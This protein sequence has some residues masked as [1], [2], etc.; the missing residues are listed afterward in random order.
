MYLLADSCLIPAGKLGYGVDLG[1]TPALSLQL[2]CSMWIMRTQKILLF[3]TCC[4]GSIFF[5]ILLIL[6]IEKY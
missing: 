5:Y 3:L 4:T 2:A 6:G 1:N